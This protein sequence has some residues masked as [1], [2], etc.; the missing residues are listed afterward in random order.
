MTIR[1]MIAAVAIAATVGLLAACDSSEQRAEKYYQ[2]G[3]EY[4]EKGDVDRALVEFRNVFKLNGRHREA[5]LAYAR[6]EMK[7]GNL[8]EA[9]GQYLRLVEQYPDDLEG[10]RALAEIAVRSA[11]WGEAKKNIDAVF[12]MAPND[13]QTMVNKTV[14]DYGK[15]TEDNDADA[16][17]RAAAQARK[18]RVDFPDNMMLRRIVIDDLLRQHELDEALT[19]LD[20]AIALDPED[21]PLYATRL[22][23]YAAQNDLDKVEAGLVEMVARFPDAPEMADALVRWY[24]ARGSMDKAEDLL[25]NRIAEKPEDAQRLLLLIRF[26]AEQRGPKAATEELSRVIDAGKGSPV[27]RSARA[28][29]LFDMGKRDEAIAEMQDILRQEVPAEDRVKI[30][31]GLARMQA[32]NGN[33]VAAR[34]LVE[35]VLAEKS[36]DV[37]ALKLKAGWLILDDNVGEAITLLRSALEVSPRDASVMTLMAQAYERDGN[38]DLMREMLAS[39]VDASGRAPEES[40]RYAAFLAADKKLLPAESVLLEALRLSPGS[41]M[42]LVPLGQVYIGM[43]DWNRAGDVA[44]QLGQM[45]DPAAHSSAEALTAAILSGQKKTAEALDYLE[46]LASAKDAGLSAKVAVVRAHLENNQIEAAEAYLQELLTHSPKEP[47]LRFLEASIKAQ[48]GDIEGAA[49]GYRALLAEDGKRLPVW[50]ALYRL[51]AANGDRAKAQSTLDE[52]LAVYPA[53][54]E[55]LWAKAGLLEQD[56]KI[57]DAIRIYEDLYR[58][59]SA[60]AI[61]ANNLASLLSS[62]RHDPESLAK[63]EVIARR[64]RGSNI[65]P[66]QDTYGW[67]AYLRGNHAEAVK[68]L[69]PA[70]QA[71]PDDPTVQYHLAKTY[72]AMGRKSDALGVYKRVLSLIADENQQEFAIEARKAVE[73]LTAAGVKAP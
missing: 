25:R 53:E 14:M 21:T 22:S 61:V 40:V 33:L 66:Y 27:L 20:Q 1:R 35:E 50:M 39:A 62:H 10:R 46:D 70:A 63:A 19:E 13:P 68:E 52:A 58:Q 15:G 51:E 29:F 12:A 5:R 2:S 59:N 56:G 65:A 72:E 36:D 42:L 64:L 34:A 26:L 55:L 32:V 4:L 8:R 18:L 54:G 6:A 73:N 7:R 71:L 44:R 43:E 30:K 69:E 67:I 38:R 24:L 49:A 28:G 45:S 11:N 47:T 23:V 9:Y 17:V 41:L 57:E 48:K 60:N 31:V 37:E 3:L 16:M